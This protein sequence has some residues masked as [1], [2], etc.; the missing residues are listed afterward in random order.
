MP[1]ACTCLVCQRLFFVKP[2]HLI[3]GEGKYCSRQCKAS[4]MRKTHLPNRLCV[5]CGT[6]FFAQP[7]HI[8]IGRGLYCSNACKKF[9]TH[10]PLE[11]RFWQQVQRCA[12]LPY[13]LY[14]C[15]PWTGPLNIYGYGRL[16]IN[17]E[18]HMAHRVSWQLH[19]KRLLPRHDNMHVIRHL[20]F[21]QYC[22]NPWHLMYGSAQENSRDDAISGQLRR[23]ELVGTAK[24]TTADVLT[25]RELHANGMSY[26]LLAQQYNVATETI[27]LICRRRAWKHLP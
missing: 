14:C 22:V 15:W 25:I 21:H 26:P 23:G 3:K 16:K 24:L 19:N 6:A 20:C 10:G 12:H 27:G 7:N 13:C 4:S 9:Y 8:R 17:A 2:S 11:Q 18:I 1:V 5:H